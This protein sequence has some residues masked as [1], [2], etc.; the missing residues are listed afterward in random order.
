MNEHTQEEME[1]FIDWEEYER[2]SNMRILN[3]CIMWDGEYNPFYLRT[4]EQKYSLYKPPI[5]PYNKGVN[6]AKESNEFHE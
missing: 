2:E 4:N 3:E 5:N 6:K 1:L